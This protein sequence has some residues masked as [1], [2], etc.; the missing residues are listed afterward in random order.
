MYT[1]LTDSSIYN[2]YYRDFCTKTEIIKMTRRFFI[3]M[4]LWFGMILNSVIIVD[5]RD[6][7][8]LL[9]R[10]CVLFKTG[11]ETRV[12]SFYSEVFA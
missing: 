3:E 8:R 5:L 6:F 4:W 2:V 10:E 7:G 12:I 1:Y 11:D 9:D